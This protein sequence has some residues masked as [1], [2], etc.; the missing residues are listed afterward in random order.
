[1]RNE[2]LH[3]PCSRFTDE[4]P[5]NP[6]HRGPY[7][8]EVKLVSW[9]GPSFPVLYDELMSG[10]GDEPS[11][12]AE[13]I[14][15]SPAWVEGALTREVISAEHATQWDALD[16][17][18]R[19]VVTAMFAMKLLP[20]PLESI[21]FT[22][23]INNVARATTHQLVRTRVGASF[24]QN[25]GRVNDWRHKAWSMPETIA[26]LIDDFDQDHSTPLPF[27]G[28]ALESCLERMLPIENYLTLLDARRTEEDVAV[29]GPTTLHDALVNHLQDGRRLYAAL[30][31]AGVPHQDARRV[32]TMGTETFIYDNYNYLALAGVLANRLE[33]TMEWEIN[34]IAQLMLREVRMQCPRVY[35]QFLMSRSDKTKVCSVGDDSAEWSWDGKWPRPAGYQEPFPPSYGPLQNPYFVLHPSSFNGGPIVWIPTNGTYPWSIVKPEAESLICTSCGAEAYVNPVTRLCDSCTRIN[36]PA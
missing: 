7:G 29:N 25:S 15:P 11:R 21:N 8:L 26:R 12:L 27:D 34:C 16:D 18:Q 19:R 22:F 20:T 14:Q 13:T 6:I 30:V 35:S 23:L 33:H 36:N 5:R 3:R 31:D 10:A 2:K 1:M 28:V 17:Y 9:N 4:E 32:L 24:A